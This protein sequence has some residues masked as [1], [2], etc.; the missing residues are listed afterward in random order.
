MDAVKDLDVS[1]LGEGLPAI[2]PAFGTVLAE[3]CAV[4]FEDQ[5]HSVGVELKVQGSF[6]KQYTVHWSN[7]TE[8]MLNCYNDHEVATEL[9][10]YG[11]AVLLIRD[12]TEYTVIRRST[13]S[14]GID[15]WLGTKKKSNDNFLAEQARLEVSGIRKGNLSTLKRRVKEKLAQTTRSAGKLPAYV[16]VI[17]FG[18]PLAEVVKI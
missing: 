8:Q 16:V 14:T 2:T 7:V 11:I 4:C 9:G 13:K 6:D 1:S 12:L 17:Q 5:G 15:Y 18:T 10:A 3:A